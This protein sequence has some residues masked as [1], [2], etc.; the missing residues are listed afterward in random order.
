MQAALN[1]IRAPQLKRSIKH[2]LIAALGAL[3]LGIAL[4]VFSKWLDALSI[5]DAVAWQHL[6][7]ML[8]LRNVFSELPV[9]LLLAAAIAVFSPAPLWAAGRVFLFFAGMTVS[10]HVY[11]VFICGFNPRSYMLLWYGAA[12]LSPL[13]AVL[14]WYA[15]GDGKIAAALQTCLL[16]C[17]MFFTFH[18]G[19]GYFSL[20]RGI[21]LLFLAGM[22]AV[23]WKGIKQT[24][25]V[26]L[27]ALGLRLLLGLLLFR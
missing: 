18:A 3:L 8:D 13:L 14:C 17:M 4:G 6:L 20:G 11:T 26:T 16:T 10:Y 19:W 15:K 7:G 24:T 27:C 1:K 9:W 22:I 5:N 25:L 21:D 2:S 23:M 12:L